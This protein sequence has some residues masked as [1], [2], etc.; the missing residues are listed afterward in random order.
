MSG[1]IARRLVQS[2][3]REKEQMNLIDQLTPKEY[4]VLTNMAE[5]SRYKEIA[6]KMGISVETVRTHIRRIYEKLQVKTKTEAVLKF[7][8]R[9]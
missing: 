6:E 4:E 1:P 7:I 8:R 2:F 5:G 3:Q 9:R